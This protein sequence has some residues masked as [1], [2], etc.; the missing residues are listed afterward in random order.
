MI[1]E[2]RRWLNVYLFLV[3][4]M[5][6]NCDHCSP[7]VAGISPRPMKNSIVTQYYIACLDA[8]VN[9]AR[10][11][12]A[13]LWTKRVQIHA[14]SFVGVRCN[15]GECVVHWVAPSMSPWEYTQTSCGVSPT[16]SE[17]TSTAAYQSHIF[18]GAMD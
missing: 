2:D 5:I 17:L 16:V 13:V 3:V 7:A 8:H 12:V 10:H 11:I 1:H 14:T 15:A 4:R 18:S 6:P 9:G